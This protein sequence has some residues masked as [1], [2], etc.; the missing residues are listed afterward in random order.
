MA[1]PVFA[2]FMQGVYADTQ[3]IKNP[4]KKFEISKAVD[5]KLDC[6]ESIQNYISNDEEF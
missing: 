3:S 4:A 6:G 2:E 5:L 1:L